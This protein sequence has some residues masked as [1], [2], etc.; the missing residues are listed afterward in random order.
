MANSDRRQERGWDG[1]ERQLSIRFY[2]VLYAC[3]RL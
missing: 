3:Q 1:R 2:H